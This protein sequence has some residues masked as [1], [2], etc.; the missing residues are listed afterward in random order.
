MHHFSRRGIAD[1]VGGRTI[2]LL[3][4]V[5]LI[6][7]YSFTAGAT[8][9]APLIVVENAGQFGDGARYQATGRG[10]TLWIA[11]DAL[12]ITAMKEK[13]SS[14][15]DSGGPAGETSGPKKG[16]AL[17]LTFPGGK[18]GPKIEPFGRLETKISYFRGSDPQ[19]WNPDVPVWSGVRYVD[20]YPGVDL[21][22]AGE[23]GILAPRFVVRDSGRAGA[24]KFFEKATLR[25]EG[26]DGLGCD[27]ETI[28]CSTGIGEV[29]FPLFGL[30]YPQ[31]ETAAKNALESA[32]SLFASA[33]SGDEVLRPFAA[34]SSDGRAADDRTGTADMRYG[35]FLG[36]SE[37]DSGAG[38]A[39]DASGNAYVTGVTD[40]TNF[41]VT[42][43]AFQTTH[44]GLLDA[45]VAKLN[46][47]GWGLI[48]GT[49]LGGSDDDYGRGIAAD[50]SGNAYVTG[51]TNSANFPVTAGAFQTIKGGFIDVFAVKL[52]AT[53]SSLIYGTF[54][55]A[56]DY[57]Y[58]AGI[59]VD[60][61]GNA[62]VTGETN[63]AAFPVTAGAFQ[64]IK[65]GFFDA[66]V[67]KLN[68]T[69]SG[70]I[71]G[72]FLG[73]NEDDYGRGIAPDASGN[74]Y[75]TGYTYSAAFPVTAGA[76][77]TTL[78]GNTDGFAAKL[79][80]AG[81]GL[82]YGTYLG[83]SG[84]EDGREIVPDA[85]GNAYVTGRTNSA[86]F[87][88]TA[89]AFRTTSGG[90]ADAFVSKLNATGS[91]LIYGTYLGGSGDDAGNGIALDPSG[92][93][94]VTGGTYSANFPVTAGAF[95]T[96]SGGGADA[97]VSRLNAT[98]SG[99]IY[100]SF[101]GESGSEWGAGI[102]VDASGN[103]Y[104]TGETHSDAFPVT[105]TGFRIIYGGNGDAFATK[106]LTG[107]VTGNS[108]GG[109]AAG[110]V[111]AIAVLLT[112][113]MLLLRK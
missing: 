1:G 71:Y 98:G 43:G 14:G 30:D 60:A 51:E 101:L 76:F 13:Q 41:P 26:A 80:A 33:V 20:L 85:S 99:L 48:Y 96:A 109:C 11:D 21:E 47:G 86:N 91:G 83:G 32:V 17:K 57:D 90:G 46:A 53:G 100:G 59:A 62:Y 36:G 3:L 10:V 4:S 67:A 65:G 55:G 64:T 45:F 9:G 111:P 113:P 23:D 37:Y 77:Q 93:A 74:A 84:D 81:S 12:W 18:T 22:I 19:K 107:A 110:I 15:E 82:I 75:V 42:A 38:I 27:S 108:G 78:E 54:L 49:F 7:S 102:A 52:N 6:L 24:A 70:L 89:G 5:L 92:N 87:P 58:G 103:A 44:G 50:A 63:S 73:G 68:A 88:V 112:F 34:A 31:G 105:I 2:I 94:Y 97:F 25:I 39:V 104:V 69:G 40:S 72:T 29:A 66:F 79:N 56:G 28:R 8:G 16:V 106:I 95:Q 35:T 61:S